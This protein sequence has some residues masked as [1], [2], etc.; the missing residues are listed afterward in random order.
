MK[1]L[2]LSD[3]FTGAL[4]TGVQLS[5]QNIP[6][7]VYVSARG[8]VPLTMEPDDAEVLV[9]NAETRHL[10]YEEAYACTQSLLKRYAV[11]GVYVY[12]KTDSALRGNIAA[13][14][15]AAVDTCGSPLMFVPAYPALGRITRQSVCYVN[16]KLLEHSI[17]RNDPRTP[18]LQSS[19]LDIFRS[20]KAHFSMCPVP[21]SGLAA[22]PEQLAAAKSDVYI[23]DC[24]T[25]RDLEQIADTIHKCGKYG[26]TAGCAGFAATLASH[27][28][29]H[30]AAPEKAAYFGPVLFVSGSANA[31]TFS[32]IAFAREHGFQVLSLADMIER[33]AQGGDDIDAMIADTPA[34]RILS[35]ARKSLS[36]N[37]PVVLA[38]ACCRE[39]LSRNNS[40]AF[41]ETVAK[42]TA[43]LVQLLI[44][45]CSVEN[46]AV[47]GGDMVTAILKQLACTKVTA[48]GEITAGVPLCTFIHQGK[49]R[50][51]ITK[52]GGFGSEDTILA[53]H[54]FFGGNH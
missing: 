13:A 21:V 10:S 22:F 11:P 48:H 4:D 1:L 51:L 18:T 6:T 19:I 14:C 33:C 38:T 54:Q 25:D 53:I 32:Q 23:F 2:I 29:F 47:F 49:L 45:Q 7:T 41:H 40:P 3:D 30:R 8:A 35:S 43:S 26:L 50:C 52:S 27:I 28:P 5:S 20:S 46:I 36:H 9:I 16:G 42:L 31:V 37:R 15:Q 34:Q 39:E 12:V 17:F 24:E 44:E